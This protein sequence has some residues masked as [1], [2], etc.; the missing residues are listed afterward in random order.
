MD[1]IVTKGLTKSKQNRENRALGREYYIILELIFSMMQSCL[2]AIVG[3]DFLVSQIQEMY[4][5]IYASVRVMTVLSILNKRTM[6]LMYRMIDINIKKSKYLS[7]AL[8]R[9]IFMNTCLLGHSYVEYE[10]MLQLRAYLV[11][12]SSVQ[13]YVPSER[14]CPIFDFIEDDCEY[15]LSVYNRD[16]LTIKVIFTDAGHDIV[17][18]TD[19]LSSY[20][21]ITGVNFM[22]PRV[23]LGQ[24]FGVDLDDGSSF[25]VPFFVELSKSFFESI[26]CIKYHIAFSE[27]VHCDACKKF[28]S[29]IEFNSIE[30][31]D[32]L[33]VFLVHRW[34]C[35]TFEILQ[36]YF[37]LFNFMSAFENI[38]EK[39]VFS[40][41]FSQ[42]KIDLLFYYLS[43]EILATLPVYDCWLDNSKV[44]KK[45]EYKIFRSG[46]NFVNNNMY[47]KSIYNKTSKVNY[48]LTQDYLRALVSDLNFDEKILM[49]N[50]H[51]K[52]FFY[53][54]RF[55]K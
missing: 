45:I 21:R 30:G 17:I 43:K 7:F 31:S 14:G 1:M 40:T 3:R 28:I 23:V 12:T 15:D 16:P 47:M 48:A 18:F 6:I 44:L 49:A 34:F 2:D 8:F 41:A 9:N 46:H 5:I 22:F 35:D 20:C 50:S 32:V 54:K 51:N 42:E 37:P 36:Q 4:D 10:R 26:S 11:V 29:K 27:Y 55:E 53:H 38:V 39:G 52:S 24:T 13:I 33:Y 19:N 25:A